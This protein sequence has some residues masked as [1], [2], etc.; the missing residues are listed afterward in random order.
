MPS[1]VTGDNSLCSTNVCYVY[2]PHTAL[3]ISGE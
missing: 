1:E 3:S 2:L